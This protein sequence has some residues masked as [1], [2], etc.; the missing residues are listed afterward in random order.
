[1]KGDSI[2]LCV[3]FYNIIV[4]YFCYMIYGLQALSNLFTSINLKKKLQKKL[5]LS[6]VSTGVP[7]PF[8]SLSGSGGLNFFLSP[9][10]TIIVS[11]QVFICLHPCETG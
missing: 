3:I 5:Y 7:F 11:L 8:A 9:L 10:Y 6:A 4:F 1:M 2:I